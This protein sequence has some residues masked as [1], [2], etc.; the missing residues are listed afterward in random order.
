MSDSLQAPTR[1]P[2]TREPAVHEP[3]GQPVAHTNG[4]RAL[5]F[6]AVV[7]GAGFSGM[8]MLYRLR[9]LGLSVRVFE[10]GDDVGGTWYWNRYPGARCD[11][12]SMDYSYSFSEDLQQEWEWSERYPSQPEVLAYA[13]HVA[14]RFDLRRDIEFETCVTSS[15]FEDER[16]RWTIQTDSGDT[17]TARFFIMA[18]G[19]LSVPNTP[20]FDGLDDFSGEVY[21][22]GEWPKDGV[23]FAGR[24]VAV[25]GTGSSGI[26]IIPHIAEDADHL[27]VF[28]RTP[29]YSVPAGNEPLDPDDMQSLKDRYDAYREEARQSPIGIPIE[30]YAES[31]LDLSA[32]ERRQVFEERWGTGGFAFLFS[33]G[34]LLVDEEAN[35][36]CAEFVRQ[37]IHNVVDDPETAERL[38]PRDYPIGTKRICLDSGY[39]Q[40]FNRDNVSLVD[41]QSDPI[42]TFTARGLRTEQAEYEF[43]TLVLATGFDAMTGALLKVD[44]RGVD[45]LRLEDKWSS[46]PRM[47]LGLMAAGFPNMFAITGPGSPSVISNMIVSIEQHVEWIADCIEHLQRE[48]VSRIEPTPQAEDE[49]VAHV[50]EAANA[51]L[52]PQANSWYVGANIEGKTRVFMPYVGGVDVYRDVCDEVA[53]QG[54]KGFTLDRLAEKADV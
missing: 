12:E 44:I 15:T 38:T 34:D 22:T 37:K 46:G 18:T 9:K 30:V 19:C 1:E 43:D 5:D 28:Q 23:D 6:D 36:M 45:G 31:A 21:H 39:F 32:E 42:Q 14:D 7:V 33:I 51:T 53:A 29:N 52:F 27:T 3:G 10:K 40:T 50:N 26:Q 8:Y 41:V 24:R 35:E 25:I 48:G 2:A 54:Y 16:H 11:V 13:R 17:V 4:R 47:H 20:D 49:W